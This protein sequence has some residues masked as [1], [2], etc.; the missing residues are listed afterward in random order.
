MYAQVACTADHTMESCAVAWVIVWK[1]APVC[2]SGNKHFFV[3]RKRHCIS[4][5]K[6][7][8]LFSAETGVCC[9][10][11]W[12]PEHPCLFFLCD[13]P[14]PHLPCSERIK[15]EVWWPHGAIM[16]SAWGQV[17][18]YTAAVRLGACCGWG[19][20]TS[21]LLWD[22]WPSPATSSA[23]ALIHRDLL[24]QWPAEQFGKLP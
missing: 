1:T 13:F 8:L 18:K 21:W 20:W 9:Y 7:G 4:G 12:W 5:V 6:W 3:I 10:V 11:W 17:S 14:F 22:H 24:W 19:A 23:A 15:Q 16:W 2:V